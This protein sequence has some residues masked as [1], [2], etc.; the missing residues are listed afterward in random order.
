MVNRHE[1]TLITLN[2]LLVAKINKLTLVVI[3]NNRVSKGNNLILVLISS[4]NKRTSLVKDLILSG[5]THEIIEDNHHVVLKLK[6]DLVRA[7]KIELVDVL[8]DGLEVV[9]KETSNV[10]NTRN[11]K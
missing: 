9:G 1:S 3:I 10:S 2:K 8:L 7:L 5:V 4:E 11:L 6:R